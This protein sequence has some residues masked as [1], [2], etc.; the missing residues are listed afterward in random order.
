MSLGEYCGWADRR[1]RK[2]ESVREDIAPEPQP[3]DEPMEVTEE[4]LTDTAVTRIR[5]WIVG[6]QR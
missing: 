4:S 3:R 1:T 5:R 6:R 2:R